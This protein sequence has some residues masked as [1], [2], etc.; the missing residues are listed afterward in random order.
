MDGPFYVSIPQT[1]L[2]PAAQNM[3]NKNWCLQQD[4][5]PKHT[6]MVAQEFIARNRIKVIDWPTYSP[7]LNPI[8]NVW[9]IFKDKVERRMPKN[10][11]ELK[12]FLAEEWDAIPENVVNN[13]IQSM[14]IR[15]ELILE[16]DGERIP[17]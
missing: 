13:L 14:K 12:Q 6:S 15:C 10:I 11:E 17:F 3:Y 16:K 9:K 1:Q 7:D 2:L 5:D 8:E 4:N